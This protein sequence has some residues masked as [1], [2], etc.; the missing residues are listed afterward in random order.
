[1]P[2]RLTKPHCAMIVLA[3]ICAC[4][5]P[6]I[7][8]EKIEVL[9]DAARGQATAERLCISCH[10]ISEDST[11]E[12][13]AGVPTFKGIANKKTQTADSIR[14]VLIAPHAPMPDVQ[15]TRIE[16]EDIISYLDR[17]RAPEA[18]PPL[19]PKK[20]KVAPKPERPEPT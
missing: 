19:H 6:A 15:L 20:K 18:G 8:E 11:A 16:I 3:V 2:T 5:S 1:M 14:N 17:L 12:V 7:S 13:P 4:S 10:V 9:P